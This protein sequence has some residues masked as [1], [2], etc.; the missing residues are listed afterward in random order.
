MGEAHQPICR[1]SMWRSIDHSVR[2]HS[3]DMGMLMVL[4]GIGQ[5][6]VDMSDAQFKGLM[7]MTVGM[8]LTHVSNIKD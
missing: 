1:S 7:L 3:M 5:G 4:A 8:I 2:T 6:W